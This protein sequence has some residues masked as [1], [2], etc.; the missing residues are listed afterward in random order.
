MDNLHYRSNFDER[1]NELI[2]SL[3][4]AVFLWVI[5]NSRQCLQ[6]Q[7]ESSYNHCPNTRL[8][9]VLS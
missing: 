9:G 8:T 4:Q 1:R 6:A 7:C 2:D 3:Q 5:Y